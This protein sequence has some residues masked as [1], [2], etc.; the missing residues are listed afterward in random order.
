MAKLLDTLLVVREGFSRD[1]EFNRTVRPVLGSGAC[2]QV[3]SRSIFTELMSVYCDETKAVA[4]LLSE[5]GEVVGTSG[6]AL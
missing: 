2:V 4:V 6:Y 5:I 3:T 1:P